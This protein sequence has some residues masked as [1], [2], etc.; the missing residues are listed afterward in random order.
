MI[1]LQLDS[2]GDIF[3]RNYGLARISGNEQMAQRIS[4]R[5]KLLLGEWFLDTGQGVPWFERILVK[6]PNRAIVQGVL[7]RTIIQTP[8][9]NELVSFDIRENTVSRKIVVSFAV[10]TN[11]GETFATGVE[12]G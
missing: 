5:L 8:G 2:S 3:T 7:K 10:T 4:T 9:V 11:N 12:M 6:S 1:N